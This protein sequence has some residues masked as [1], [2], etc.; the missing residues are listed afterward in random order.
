VANNTGILKQS[1]NVVFSEESNLV[2]IKMVESGA[3][4]LAFGQNG[5]PAQARLKTLQT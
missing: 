5:A 4:V 1:L 3:K 2:E